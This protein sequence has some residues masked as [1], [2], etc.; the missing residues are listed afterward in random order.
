MQ[1]LI[2]PRE[3]G[4]SIAMT[5]SVCLFVCLSVC[6]HNSKTA[7]PNFTIL[8]DCLYMAVAWSRYDT[9]CASGFADEVMFSYSRSNGPESST[10]LCLD[11]VYRFD[12]K[13]TMVFIRMWHGGGANLLYTI[14]LLDT[15]VE[16]RSLFSV[17]STRITR[18]PHDRTSPNFCECSMSP[19]LDPALMALQYAICISGFVDDVVFSHNGR[20]ARHASARSDSEAQQPRFQR[21]FARR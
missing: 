1:F 7:R 4:C 20:V 15:V 13:T 12:I 11:D 3:G 17:C 16:Q 8:C 9:L 6:L 21:D 10:T 14:D 5:M 2:C 19:W 18:E